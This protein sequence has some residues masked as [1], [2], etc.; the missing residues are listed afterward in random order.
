MREIVVVLSHI[1]DNEILSAMVLNWIV[2]CVQ[3]SRKLGDSVE[4]AQ[5]SSQIKAAAADSG[6]SHGADTR[7]SS[8]GLSLLLQ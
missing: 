5:H 4:R 6:V 7:A 2:Q 1:C 8:V 3:V